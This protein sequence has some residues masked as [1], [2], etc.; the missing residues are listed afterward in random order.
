MKIKNEK[1]D[2]KLQDKIVL[3]KMVSFGNDKYDVLL[4][5]TKK[6][7]TF[8]KKKG[9]F[10]KKYKVVNTILISDI[11]II[12][13]K[14]KIEQEKNKI[15]LYTNDSKIIFMGNNI[16]ETKKIVEEIKKIASGDNFLERLSKKGIKVLNVT[17]KSA[18][19]IGSVALAAAGTYKAIKENKDVVKDA[20]KTL[21]G[22]IKK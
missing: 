1:N 6:A 19:I 7:I 13:D 5:I 22:S 11:K 12:N 10:K 3:E 17:K 4:T 9:L 16:L 18:K 14:V 21:I 8:S 2:V 20:T 15:I